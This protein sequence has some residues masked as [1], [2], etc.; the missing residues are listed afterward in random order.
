MSVLVG[1]QV[2]GAGADALR[3]AAELAAAARAPL[4][5][6]TV[7]LRARNA[8]GARETEAF[9]ASTRDRFAAAEEAARRELADYADLDLRVANRVSRSAGQALVDGV[10]EVDAS[11]LVL[12]S[13]PGA[14][15]RIRVGSVAQRIM[16]SSP[17]PVAIAP[18]G[19]RGAPR[20]TALRVTAAFDGTDENRHVVSGALRLAHRLGA[21]TRIATFGVRGPTMYPP[22][23]GLTAE[24][25]VLDEWREQMTRRLRSVSA[26]SGPA[27]RVP[28]VIGTGGDWDTALGGVE[29]RVGDLLAVGTTPQTGIARVFLGTRG[30]RILTH[31]PV[32]VVV[33][34]A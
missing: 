21:A 14:R 30:T 20:R 27:G 7:E 5:V 8:G 32:P 29:W 4:Q 24:D 16:H 28:A 26:E 23:V 3:F 22:E 15:G 25:E 33:L 31:S 10:A 17:V 1:F 19:Y 11:L 9:T 18:H 13:A 6:M 34:P 2:G 12:G